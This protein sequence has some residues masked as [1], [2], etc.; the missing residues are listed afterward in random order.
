MRE[1]YDEMKEKYEELEMKVILI[2]TRDTIAASGGSGC[3]FETPHIPV[4]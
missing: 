3:P 1:Q 4:T 2:E